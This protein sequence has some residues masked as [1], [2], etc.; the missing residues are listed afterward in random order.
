MHGGDHKIWR[1]IKER[2]GRSNAMILRL[3]YST[4]IEETGPESQ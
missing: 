1:K 3:I 2:T 4:L